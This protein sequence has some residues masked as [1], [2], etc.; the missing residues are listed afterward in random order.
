MGVNTMLTKV[1]KETIFK[2]AFD[3]WDTSKA[4]S[5]KEAMG[6]LCLIAID[7]TEKLV[8]KRILKRISQ[9]EYEEFKQKWLKRQK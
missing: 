8:V 7:E 4:T 3:L 6:N 5:F 2:N 1:D 9:F